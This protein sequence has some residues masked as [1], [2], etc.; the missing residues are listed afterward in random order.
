MTDKR[1]TTNTDG[2]TKRRSKR[3]ESLG[4]TLAVFNVWLFVGLCGT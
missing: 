3:A 2:A 4:I 1:H